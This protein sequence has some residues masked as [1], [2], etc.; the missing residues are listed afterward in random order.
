MNKTIE[1][2]SY[3]GLPARI[4]YRTRYTFWPAQIGR[5]VLGEPKHGALEDGGGKIA[6]VGDVV[7]FRTPVKNKLGDALAPDA[8]VP[9]EGISRQKDLISH[10][11]VGI[12]AVICPHSQE[13]IVLISFRAV[14]GDN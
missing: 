11:H 13:T 4:R 3:R 5:P 14:R 8:T 6:T 10:L 9:G 2:P 1:I 12:Y 7:E